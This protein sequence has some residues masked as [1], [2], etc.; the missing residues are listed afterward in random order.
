MTTGAR[1][2]P[3]W[4]PAFRRQVRAAP[5]GAPAAVRQGGLALLRRRPLRPS[6][7][8]S[9]ARRLRTAT[10]GCDQVAAAPAHVTGSDALRQE[11]TS[12]PHAK[13]RL[14]TGSDVSRASRAGIPD[15][16]RAV[17]PLQTQGWPRR[18]FHSWRWRWSLALSVSGN[19][20]AARLQSAGPGPAWSRMAPPAPAASDRPLRHWEARTETGWL[21]SPGRGIRGADRRPL[22]PPGPVGTR[23][24][25]EPPH[26]R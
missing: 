8:P 7:V 12:S 6:G 3:G 25:R 10:V 15:A 13:Q 22:Q 11:V 1:A 2:R 23:R 4:S 20:N 14:Q 21:W 9:D 24:R 16:T 18:P 17:R 5:S 19:A 26:R